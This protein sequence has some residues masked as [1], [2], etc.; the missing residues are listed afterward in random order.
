MHLLWQRVVD[1][2]GGERERVSFTCK[3]TSRKLRQDYCKRCATVRFRQS[4]ELWFALSVCGTYDDVTYPLDP[5]DCDKFSKRKQKRKA[6]VRVAKLK[7]MIEHWILQ[8]CFNAIYVKGSSTIRNFLS[9]VY[10]CWLDWLM[11]FSNWS[12]ERLLL[13]YL[14][15]D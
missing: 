7:S 15:N 1:G 4:L 3:L 12:S 9:E 6:K 2:R 13:A 11:L 14:I 8:R 10:W 5:V